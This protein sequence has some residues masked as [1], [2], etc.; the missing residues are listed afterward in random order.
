MQRNQI[1]YR[2]PRIGTEIRTPHLP[3]ERLQHQTEFH[4][5]GGA[6]TRNSVAESVLPSNFNQRTLVKSTT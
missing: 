4:I 6:A 5:A 3:H 2:K 1:S